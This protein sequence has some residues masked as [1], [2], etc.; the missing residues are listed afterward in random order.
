ML[1]SGIGY[2]KKLGV[3]I[4]WFVYVFGFTSINTLKLKS[5]LLYPCFNGKEGF[6]TKK[7]F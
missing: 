6:T 2:M 4:H 1:V 3:K 7:K 5:D